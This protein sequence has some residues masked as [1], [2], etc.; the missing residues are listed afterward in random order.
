VWRWLGH[1]G[2]AAESA[3]WLRARGFIRDVD[4]HDIQHSQRP[5]PALDRGENTITFRAG[6]PEG[7]ITVE[8]AARRDA[9]GK[10]LLYT[11]FHP[12]VRGFDSSL[13]ID[14]NGRGGITFPVATPG[15][16]VRLRFGAHYRARDAQDGLDYQV[17]L[18]NGCSWKSVARAAGPTPG[19]C[20]YVTFSDIPSG[21]RSAL[22]RY[23]GTNHNVTGI[24]N[25][26]I[27]ADYRE[28]HGGFRPVKVTYTWEEDG[29]PKEH[30]YFARQPQQTYAIRC[31]TKP[32]MKAIVL[33]LAE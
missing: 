15:D 30:T 4:E 12:E 10:Q 6:P 5:L 21:T 18:D 29:Q 3:Y 32:L 2:P 33:E 17:S 27:D 23:A 9:K 31:P 25:F 19:N 16:L 22:V 11:D 1:F 28:P 14:A 20:K 7:T 24:F 26:R 8:G 13:F